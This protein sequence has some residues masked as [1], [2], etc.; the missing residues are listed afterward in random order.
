MRTDINIGSNFKDKRMFVLGFV[1]V[2]SVAD[3]LRR[4]VFHLGVMTRSQRSF[5]LAEVANSAAICIQNATLWTTFPYSVSLVCFCSFNFLNEYDRLCVIICQ[6]WLQVCKSKLASSLTDAEE[7][8]TCLARDYRLFRR[9]QTRFRKL[10]NMFSIFIVILCFFNLVQLM[11]YITDIS[12]VQ[13]NYWYVYM[14][15]M[16]TLV[17]IFLL[18]YIGNLN[19]ARVS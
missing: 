9:V 11:A 19:Q 8:I 4:I 12:A 16:S 6:K 3:V 7:T 1:L 14:A 17:Y 13:G 10:T 5:S 2:V 15:L 18:A